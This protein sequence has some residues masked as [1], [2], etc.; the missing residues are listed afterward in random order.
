MRQ[1]EVG[2]KALEQPTIIQCLKKK[3]T[4]SSRILLFFLFR[5]VVTYNRDD[6][7]MS[8]H[9][10]QEI[11]KDITF[12][13]TTLFVSSSPLS[14]AFTICVYFFF[15]LHFILSIECI[16][17]AQRYCGRWN[18]F[19]LAVARWEFLSLSSSFLRNSHFFQFTIT[20]FWLIPKPICSTKLM[21]VL[22]QSDCEMKCQNETRFS[23]LTYT[24][25]FYKHLIFIFFFCSNSSTFICPERMER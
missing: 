23:L 13:P 15:E 12:L 5:C 18:E 2:W 16:Q 17:F 1:N 20:S 25:S 24:I 21:E 6:N 14:E 11:E 9:E 4:I 8:S 3:I 10:I 19:V 7:K 22:T